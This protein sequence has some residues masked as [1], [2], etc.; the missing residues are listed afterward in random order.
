MPPS[1]AQPITEQQWNAY[2]DTIR[3]L[4]LEEELSQAEIL[5]TLAKRGFHVTRA[6]LGLQ[7]KK[8]NF[9][10]RLK[11]RHWEAIGHRISKRKAAGKDS[12]VIISGLRISERKVARQARR[13]K[14]LLCRGKSPVLEFD[15]PVNISTPRSPTTSSIGFAWKTKLPWFEFQD[16]L[17]IYAFPPS[18]GPS[19][20]TMTKI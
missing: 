14:P 1:T 11:P 6:Q 13:C 17:N 19:L 15:V 12:A 8:W 9:C 5:T 18:T 4:V 3:H 20:R 16:C 10:R 2:K 7:L